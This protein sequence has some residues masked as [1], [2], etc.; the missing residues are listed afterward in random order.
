MRIRQATNKVANGDLTDNH[1]AIA[2]YAK[3]LKTYRMI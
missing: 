3:A 1:F 2:D